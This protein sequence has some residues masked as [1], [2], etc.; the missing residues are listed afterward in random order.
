MLN[1]KSK[2]FVKHSLIAAMLAVSGTFA[3]AQAHGGHGGPG[4]M[5]EMGGGHAGMM[6]G[7]MTHMLDAADATDAQRAQIKQI[8][9][10]AR[11]DLKTQME[12]G[13][14]LHEQA[15]ALFT[16]PTIDAAAIE[17][18][19][20]QLLAHHDQ[21][22][23]RMSLAMIDAAKV[24]SA[25]QR[26]KLAEKMKKMHEHRADRMQDKMGKPDTPKAPE[27]AAKPMN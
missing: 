1:L 4:G 26:A 11:A 17:K 12:A 16:A 10:S 27:K 6:A 22:S 21:A 9:E 5:E 7:R 15:Q 25:E 19:R 18:L 23:K 2:S 20:L 14:K 13:R 3:L 8:M 24:L